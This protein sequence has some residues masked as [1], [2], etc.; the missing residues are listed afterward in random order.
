MRHVRSRQACSRTRRH[1]LSL[2]AQPYC[3]S[4]SLAIAKGKVGLHLQRWESQRLVPDDTLCGAMRRRSTQVNERAQTRF[5]TPCRGS[6]ISLGAPRLR[7]MD[8]FFYVP[9]HGLGL[10]GIIHGKLQVLDSFTSIVGLIQ[11]A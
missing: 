2:Y 10:V 8:S 9:Y 1:A 6:K 4:K 3:E 11:A 5:W 7:V